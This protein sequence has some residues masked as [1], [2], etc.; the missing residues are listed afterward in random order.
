MMWCKNFTSSFKTFVSIFRYCSDIAVIISTTDRASL[1]NYMM[2]QMAAT[3]MPYLSKPFREIVDLYRKSLTGIQ[4]EHDRWE[5]C[6]K[7]TERFFSYLIT[8]MFAESARKEAYALNGEQQKVV[9]KYLFD[10]LKHNVAKSITLSDNY[11]YPTRRAAIEKLKNMTIQIGTPTFLLDRAYLKILYKDLLVQKTDFFQNILYGVI[12]LRKREENKLI[13]PSEETRWLDA[14]NSKN[15][16]YIPSSNKVVVPEILLRPPL[17]H[18]GFPN[19]VNMGG[20]GFRV[21]E[22]MLQGVIGQGLLFDSSGRLLVQQELPGMIPF[23]NGSNPISLY[24]DSSGDPRAVLE[25][26]SMCLITK[27]VQVSVDDRESIIRG[28]TESTMTVAALRQA[29]VTLEDIL[30]LEKGIVLPA[31]ETYDPQAIFFLSFAQSMCTQRTD[32]QY[33]VDRTSHNK[34]LEKPLLI[35]ALTQF[36]EF[37]H[38]FYCGYDEDLNC[39]NVV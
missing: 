37:H 12:Y 9:K 18:P 4:R 22:A 25:K 1:N 29:Y 16:E 7:T 26:D 2:W 5:F 3:F 23:H 36:P 15:V 21:S 10:Y 33:D 32:Q 28:K 19:S 39:G 14:V 8:A 17:F 6:E 11:D 31:M 30:E 27:Y 38:F 35:G 24:S 20:L 13:S 34:L